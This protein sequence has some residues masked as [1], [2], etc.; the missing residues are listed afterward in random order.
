M[1]STMNKKKIIVILRDNESFNQLKEI[2]STE[3][4]LLE[5]SNKIKAK[6]LIHNDSEKIVGLLFEANRAIADDF[7]F[8]RSIAEDMRFV[9]ITSIAVS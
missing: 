8:T 5:I 3:Y 1:Y 4:E 7:S 2:L 6:E 9:Q